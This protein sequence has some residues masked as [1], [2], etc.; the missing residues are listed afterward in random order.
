MSKI[1][2]YLQDL[3]TDKLLR[4]VEEMKKSTHGDK[5]PLRQIV[6]DVWGADTGIF[7]LRVNE[8]LWPMTEILSQRL[9]EETT[10][11]PTGKR[12]L[13]DEKIRQ[14][15]PKMYKA[16]DKLINCDHQEHLVVRLNDPESAAVESMKKILASIEKY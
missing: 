10:N 9:V 8:M 3:S 11:R 2:T 16:I 7:V 14:F 5:S 12:N 4:L 1:K 15:A 6:N 13:K